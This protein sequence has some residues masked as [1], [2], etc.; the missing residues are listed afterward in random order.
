MHTPE[1]EENDILRSQLIYGITI[2][3]WGSADSVSTLGGFFS[4]QKNSI[5]TL[6]RVSIKSRY[7][8]GHTKKYFVDNS[9]LAAHNLYFSSN[10]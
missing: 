1:Y 10:L 9:I 6:F 7:C 8:P 2:S 4:A 5:R 3:I